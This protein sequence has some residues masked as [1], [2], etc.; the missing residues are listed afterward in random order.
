[1][2]TSVAFADNQTGRP[3]TQAEVGDGRRGEVDQRAGPAVDL[4][5]DPVGEQLEAGDGAGP[6]VARARVVGAL[7]VHRDR[8]RAQRD[9]HVGVARTA[10]GR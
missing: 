1:M 3:G 7:G 9:E 2:S 5:A 6:H 4:G 8:G 10:A